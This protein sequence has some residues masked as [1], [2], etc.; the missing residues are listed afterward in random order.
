MK[1]MSFEIAK[2]GMPPKQGLYDPAN[3]K[4]NCGVAFVAHIKGVKSHDIVCKGIEALDNLTHRGAVG[5]DPRTGDGAGILIQIPHQFFLK[6]CTDID[7]N[8]PEEGKYGVGMMFLPS[9]PEE[10]RTCEKIIEDKVRQEGQTLLGWRDVP[11]DPDAVGDSARA[12]M[13]FMRQIFIGSV[14]EDQLAFERKLFVIRKQ[15]GFAIRGLNLKDDRL[16]HVPSLS[17]RTIVYKGQLIAAQVPKFFHDLSDETMVSALALVHQRY[18]T[19]TFPSWD[20]AHPFRYLAHNGE[21]NTLD[22]NVNWMFSREAMFESELFGDD[23]KKVTPIIRPYS[24]DSFGL[25]NAL[26]LL[27]MA[28]RSLPHAMM[29]LVPEAWSKDVHIDEDKRGFYEFHPADFSR[30]LNVAISGGVLSTTKSS[31][32]SDAVRA[33][34]SGLLGK[35]VTSTLILYGPSGI[36][37]VSNVYR[38]FVISSSISFQVVSPSPLK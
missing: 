20:L 19:N 27:V 30:A 7:I 11:V 16:F 18:S 6:V 36:E 15:L 35:S 33:S 22:G 13:P 24:S 14:C 9:N 17:S 25:D 3:E 8:L 4:D 31:L 38:A 1:K 26:E 21:I 32:T 10:R 23:I 29:M 37:T 12:V 28:G 2:G 5:A 34:G